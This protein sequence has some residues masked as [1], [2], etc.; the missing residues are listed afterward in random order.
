MKLCYFAF[1][2]VLSVALVSVY[3]SN[4][5]RRLKN[6]PLEAKQTSRQIS[7]GLSAVLISNSVRA[8]GDKHIKTQLCD[9]N[10]IPPVKSGR[11]HL[12]LN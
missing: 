2:V 7:R 8:S 6:K 10:G 4:R 9:F 12:T 1:E 5:G 11:R 3:K